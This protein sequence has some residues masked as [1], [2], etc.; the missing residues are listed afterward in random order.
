MSVPAFCSSGTDWTL[1]LGPTVTLSGE[2][3][4][5]NLKRLR[6]LKFM[7]KIPQRGN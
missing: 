5:Q 6:Q 7:G 4:D 1:A 3:G 2:D